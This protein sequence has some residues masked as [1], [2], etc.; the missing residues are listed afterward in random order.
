M[1]FKLNQQNKTKN[2]LFL[3]KIGDDEEQQMW[4]T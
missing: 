1:E 4:G 3:I 2:T